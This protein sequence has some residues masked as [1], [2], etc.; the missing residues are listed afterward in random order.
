[1]CPQTPPTAISA[2][3]PNSLWPPNDKPVA[4]NV[5]GRVISGTQSIPAGGTT[6]FV[7][8]EYGVVQPSG[9]FELGAGGN[10]SFEV[11]LV[12]DRN[13]NDL[14]GRT[15]TITVIGQDTIGNVGSCSA[16]VTVPHDQGH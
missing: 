16:V 8:D 7:I 1:M 14:D 10:Y 4:V 12:A 2:V 5:S 11:S 13:G 9:S 3:S 15:Y 6:F